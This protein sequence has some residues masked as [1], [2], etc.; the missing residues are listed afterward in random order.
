MGDIVVD[1]CYKPHKT[2]EKVNE[3]SIG[4]MRRRLHDSRHSLEPINNP[5]ICYGVIWLS[6]AI[7]RFL[8]S[9]DDNFLIE[10]KGTLPDLS[11]S[12]REKETG[13]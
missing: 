4:Q 6:A 8:K 7:G 3:A 5:D 12:D 9:A 11:L 2:R 1:A 13:M 10:L